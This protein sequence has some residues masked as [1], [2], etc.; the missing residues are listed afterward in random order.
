MLDFPSGPLKNE[1]LPGSNVHCPVEPI[2]MRVRSIWKEKQKHKE[3]LNKMLGT[4][5]KKNWS[6][7]GSRPNTMLL[8]GNREGKRLALKGAEEEPRQAHSLRAL[9]I[10][11]TRATQGGNWPLRC[12][13]E[14]LHMTDSLF[15]EAPWKCRSENP[16][17]SCEHNSDT[18]NSHASIIS[19]SWTLIPRAKHIWLWVN[20]NGTIFG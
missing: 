14:G 3:A 5:T 9:P 11:G 1:S 12:Q 10:F 13:L 16:V 17:L 2:W 8:F 20:T 18:R 6:F 15:K 19:V 4:P 7:K